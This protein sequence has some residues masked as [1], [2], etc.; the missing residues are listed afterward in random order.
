MEEIGI[1]VS[2]P[3]PTQKKAGEFGK[4]KQEHQQEKIDKFLGEDERVIFTDI[5]ETK[6]H[7]DI[8]VRVLSGNLSYIHKDC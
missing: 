7:H 8:T 4:I 2:P 6:G 3:P 1:C 5:G